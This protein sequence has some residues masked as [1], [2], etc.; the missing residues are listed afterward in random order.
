VNSLAA[1]TPTTLSSDAIAELP[2][3]PLGS[4]DGVT[5]RTLWSSGSS[6]AGVLQVSAGHRLGVHAHRVNHHHIWILAGHAEILG[7]T[8]G[9]GSYAHIPSG[10]DHDIDATDTHG[11]TVFYLYVV[12]GE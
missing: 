5:H 4:S 2:S 11:C 10:C 3:V 1:P 7:E 8:L 9:P 12:P 6:S